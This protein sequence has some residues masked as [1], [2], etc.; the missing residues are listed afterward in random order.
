MDAE[1]PVLSSAL[2]LLPSD[3]SIID[4]SRL[5]KSVC[6]SAIRLAIFSFLFCSSAFLP[7]TSEAISFE[8]SLS[9]STSPFTNWI[10]LYLLLKPLKIAVAIFLQVSYPQAEQS[11]ARSESVRLSIVTNTSSSSETLGFFAV[12]SADLSV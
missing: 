3:I 11:I 6:S 1:I 4:V 2:L 7:S 10:Q 8:I 5:S 9:F 12:T